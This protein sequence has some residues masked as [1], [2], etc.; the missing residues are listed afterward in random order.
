MPA[1]H[2]LRGARRAGGASGGL[3][4]ASL[5]PP[6]YSSWSFGF[7]YRL[8]NIKNKQVYI[9]PRQRISLL[10]C[11]RPQ[12]RWET[13]TPIGPPRKS[14]SCPCVRASVRRPEHGSLRRR[15]ILTKNQTTGN[16][17]CRVGEMHWFDSFAEAESRR[18]DEPKISACLNMGS[19][20]K[21]SR[22]LR[23]NAAVAG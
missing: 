7:M 1:T 14:M 17:L 11:I 3:W 10:A 22:F 9:V 21:K 2:L 5:S 19:Q 6:A 18:F 4:G 16:S 12:P 13:E 20:R 15:K 8:P 23:E